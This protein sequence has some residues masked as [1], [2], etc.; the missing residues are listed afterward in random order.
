MSPRLTRLRVEFETARRG[1]HALADPL[2]DAAWTRRPA[3]REWSAAECFV[4][5]NLASRAFVP[6]LA[7][8]LAHGRKHPGPAR[9]RMDIPGILLWWA[10]TWRIPVKT[11]EPFVPAGPEPQSLVLGEFDALQDRMVGFVGEAD[12]LDLVAVG[13]VSPFDARLRYNA[14]AALRII[15]AHQRLHFA[16]AARAAGAGRG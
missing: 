8:A 1:A 12:G 14:Y 10:L 6:L 5:L 7:E 16:Q 9:C 15:V 4:H 13:I 3:P 11:T 2:E